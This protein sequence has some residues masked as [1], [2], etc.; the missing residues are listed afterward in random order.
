MTL[1]DLTDLTD[2]ELIAE[3]KRGN[4]AGEGFAIGWETDAL[5]ALDTIGTFV[6]FVGDLA[7]WERD[8]TL[9]LVGDVHGPWA[10][11]VEA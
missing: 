1:A 9:I 4:D 2:A 3:W 10:V 8:G 11:T 7:A 5:D 6:R